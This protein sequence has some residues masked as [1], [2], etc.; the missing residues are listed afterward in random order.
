ME[1]HCIAT[2]LGKGGK[3]ARAQSDVMEKYH[4]GMNWLARWYYLFPAGLPRCFGFRR[5][6]P[7]VLRPVQD[8]SHSRLQIKAVLERLDPLNARKV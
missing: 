5:R 8:K 6:A 4:V 3:R 1:L 2:A 7:P